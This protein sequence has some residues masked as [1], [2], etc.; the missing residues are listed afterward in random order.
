MAHDHADPGHNAPARHLESHAPQR[1]EA[2]DLQALSAQ[3]IEGFRTASDKAAFLRLAGVPLEIESES[4]GP[5]LKLI[6]VSVSSQWSVAAASPAFGG[7]A[8]SHLPYPGDMI[9]ERIN[10]AFTY[11]SLKERR[12]LDLRAFLAAAKAL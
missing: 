7:G 11:V 4:G 8:L 9:K 2:S 10:C 5:P 12:D 6:D 3:F 1:D